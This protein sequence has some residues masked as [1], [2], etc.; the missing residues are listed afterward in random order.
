MEF[1]FASPRDETAIKQ[2]LET[3][4]LP[5]QDIEPADLQHF[6]TAR[7]ASVMIGLVGL[8][9]NGNCALLRSLAVHL[10]YRNQGLATGLVDKIEDYAR[11]LNINTLYL[12][13]LT[14]EDFF[15]KCGFQKTARATAPA[16]IQKTAEFRELCP[17]TAAFMTKRL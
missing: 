8:Q 12:L 10:D 4:D 16:G 6:L 9:I 13:T 2:F 3:N 7:D 14:A 5:H 17:A 1:V 15:S 11:S